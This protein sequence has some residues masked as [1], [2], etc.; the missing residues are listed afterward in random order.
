[1]PLAN[2]DVALR[3]TVDLRECAPFLDCRTVVGYSSKAY[4][5][6]V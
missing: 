2:V 5:S 4:A 3:A 6:C 1:M